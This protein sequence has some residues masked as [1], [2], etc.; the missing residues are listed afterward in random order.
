MYENDPRKSFVINNFITFYREVINQKDFVSA[1]SKVSHK[2][3]AS[4]QPK[5]DK[6]TDNK[7]ESS[8]AP[9]MTQEESLQL[10]VAKVS[11]NLLTLLEEQTLAAA[12]LTGDY[13]FRY[14]EEAQRIMVSL[15]DEILLHQEWPG[16]QKWEKYLLEKRF[17]KTHEAGERFFTDLEEFLNKRDMQSLEMANLY[18]TAL[19]LGF[20]GKYRNS[21]NMEEIET[22]KN[23]LF[24]FIN[25]RQAGLYKGD[26]KVCPDA[27]QHTL[28]EG[29]IKNLV[30]PKTWALIYSCI[31]FAFFVASFGVWQHATKGLKKSVTTLYSLERM[32]KAQEAVRDNVVV[33]E[34]KK[35]V[36][37]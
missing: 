10:S 34:S 26:I 11:D 25:R 33:K 14:F 24:V 21:E 18:L 12:K 9:K 2:E 17:Y 36:R 23:R 37:G 7:S 27:Y 28:R 30:S 35:L 8:A 5:D 6:A 16:K 19:G 13:G 29:H 15:A 20:L 22:Y 3:D 4:S 31:L 32:I 1:Q